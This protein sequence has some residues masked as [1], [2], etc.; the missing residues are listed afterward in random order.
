MMGPSHALSGAAVG[1]TASAVYSYTTSTPPSIPVLIMVTV[2]VAGGALGPDFDSYGSTVV[3]SFGI[4][5]RLFY[6]LVNA[7]SVVIYNATKTSHEDMKN[8]GHRTLL[9]TG[10]SALVVGGLASL[11]TL[12][13]GTLTLWDHTYTWG[14]FNGL[15]IMGIFLNL[16]LAGLF[17]PVRAVRKKVGPYIMMLASVMF[18]FAFAYVVPEAN[19]TYAWLGLAVGGGWFVHL[20]GDLI[21]KM[22]VPLFW[23]LKLHG[24]RWYDVSLPTFMRIKA[25]GKFENV[26]LVPL[27]TV[28]VIG[29]TAWNGVMLTTMG[30]AV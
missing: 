2:I 14:Q 24:K 8:N 12:S 26:I 6:Y 13:T 5:G 10:I 3:K 28:V 18:T 21:T 27:F 17:E 9:H 23:P 4:F 16:A 11:A 1:L 15:I 7:V 25:G 19:N 20:L 29:A 22:G 30:G